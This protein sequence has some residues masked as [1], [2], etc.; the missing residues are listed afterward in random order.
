MAVQVCPDSP[1]S[2]SL[3]CAYL[4]DELFET[5]ETLQLSGDIVASG[6]HAFDSVEALGLTFAR[7]RTAGDQY[8]LSILYSRCQ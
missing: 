6:G 7:F 2:Y 5:V 4:R 1:T 8:E 3:K